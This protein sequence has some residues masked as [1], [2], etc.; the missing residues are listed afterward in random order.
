MKRTY[1]IGFKDYKF[2]KLY[3]D[4]IN[5]ILNF[6][7]ENNYSYKI[8]INNFEI[9]NRNEIKEFADKKIE[10]FEINIYEIY[11]KIKYERNNTKR[12]RFIRTLQSNFI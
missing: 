5:D 9:E 7:E 2:S 12:S 8:K 6:I 11:S 4:E 3:L 1:S 10:Y